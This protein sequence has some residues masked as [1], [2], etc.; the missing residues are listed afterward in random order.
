[1]ASHFYR[2]RMGAYAKTLFRSSKRELQQRLWLQYNVMRLGYELGQ[3]RCRSNAAVASRE[4]GA[5]SFS[6][7][8]TTGRTGFFRNVRSCAYPE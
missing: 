4:R 7:R 3:S 5:E 1:M 6:T 8:S 2:L